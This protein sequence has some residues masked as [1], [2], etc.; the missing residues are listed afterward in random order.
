MTRIVH[1][2]I[3]AGAILGAALVSSATGLGDDAGMALVMGLTSAA[4]VSLYNG[5]GC[6]TFTGCAQ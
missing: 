2:L 6:G 3:W 5:G 4:W 1:S